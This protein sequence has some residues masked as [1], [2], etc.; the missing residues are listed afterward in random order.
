M[1]SGDINAT[2]FGVVLSAVNPNTFADKNR[3]S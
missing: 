3:D 1:D 2:N